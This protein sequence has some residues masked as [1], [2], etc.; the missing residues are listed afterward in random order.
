MIERA[1]W[2]V[3]QKEAVERMKELKG[4]YEC[5]RRAM[6]ELERSDERLF[7]GAKIGKEEREGK[8]T[9]FP[10]TLRVP[11]ETPPVKKWDGGAIDVRDK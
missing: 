3:K 2:I 9:V 11:T 1:W 7:R 4:K 8:V 5:M 10:R 6:E